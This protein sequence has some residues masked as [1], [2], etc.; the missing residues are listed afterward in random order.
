MTL[1]GYKTYLVAAVTVIYAAAAY[2]LGEI[3][4]DQAAQMISTALGLSALRA[5]VAK[6]GA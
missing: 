6:V 5:G 4:F 2:W 3:M 1:P